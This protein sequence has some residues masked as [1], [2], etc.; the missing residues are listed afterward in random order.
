M[1]LHECSLTFSQ[2]FLKDAC[3]LWPTDDDVIRHSE[4][5]SRMKD[6]GRGT[7]GGVCEAINRISTMAAAHGKTQHDL[8]RTHSVQFASQLTD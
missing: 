3:G 2:A 5:I 4:G 6:E 8:A 7:K 1:N